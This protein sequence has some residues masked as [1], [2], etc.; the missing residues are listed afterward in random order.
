MPLLIKKIVAV[1]IKFIYDAIIFVIVT[2]LRLFIIKFVV[3]VLKLLCELAIAT[4][5]ELSFTY[6]VKAESLIF[7]LSKIFSIYFNSIAFLTKLI[8]ALPLF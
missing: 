7:I 2:Y 5:I 1:I 8:D 6:P 3:Y 4:Y